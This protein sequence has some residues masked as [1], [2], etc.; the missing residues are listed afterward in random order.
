MKC[1]RYRFARI[2][3]IAI[4]ATLVFSIVASAQRRQ[5]RVTRSSPSP[6]AKLDDDPNALVFSRFQFTTLT[7]SV[8]DRWD[9]MPHFDEILL[10]Y[11]RRNT[12]I[13]TSKKRWNERVIRVDDY[14]KIYTNP[15][16]FMTSDGNFRFS[17]KEAETLGEF[18]KRGGFLYADD[19]WADNPPHDRFYRVFTEEIK[20]TLPGHEMKVMPYD[21]PI[22]HCFFD[23]K[24]G[25]P[26]TKGVRHR[27]MGLFYE[28]RL[29]A[30]LTAGDVHCG[31]G[32]RFVAPGMQEE[33]LKFG[34]NLMVYALTH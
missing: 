9:V 1:I 12:N 29:V 31:W 23:F 25:A 13:K 17:K 7:S 20:K 28:G 6:T 4:I 15:I 14:E 27:D 33:C 30:F 22:Y 10:D 19:C 34:V 11:L 24:R 32:N 3:L 26:W 16:L 21:H 2:A 18:F 8:A 5:P